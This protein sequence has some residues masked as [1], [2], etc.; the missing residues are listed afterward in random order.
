MKAKTRYGNGGLK[1]VEKKNKDV[2]KIIKNK[3]TVLKKSTTGKDRDVCPLC[4]WQLVGSDAGTWCVNSLC[5]VLD[6]ADDYK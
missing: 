6:D 4:G 3:K 1:G 5:E 2:A